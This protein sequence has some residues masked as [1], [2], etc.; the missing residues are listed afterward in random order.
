MGVFH[1]FWIVQ[2]VP[3]RATHHICSTS[4]TMTTGGLL[5]IPK[6]HLHWKLNPQRVVYIGFLGWIMNGYF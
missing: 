1:V 3:N 6:L 2:M 5:K 4:A